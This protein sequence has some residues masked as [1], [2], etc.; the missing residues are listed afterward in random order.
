MNPTVYEA[1]VDHVWDFDMSDETRD[2]V[3]TK[4]TGF[5]SHYKMVVYS[6]LMKIKIRNKLVDMDMVLS[7]ETL[8]ND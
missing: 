4:I 7:L 5:P 1:M 6:K 8:Q 2:G 3:I